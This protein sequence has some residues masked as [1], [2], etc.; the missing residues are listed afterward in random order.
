[1]RGPHKFL[2]LSIEIQHFVC[3]LLMSYRQEG[4]YLKEYRL[5]KLREFFETKCFD[6]V[7]KLTNVL[8]SSLTVF[9]L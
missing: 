5:Q 4:V 3:L 7:T 6:R 2:F 1:M 9:N 8:S